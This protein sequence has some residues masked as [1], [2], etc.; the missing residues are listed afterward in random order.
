MMLSLSNINLRFIK[1]SRSRI[2]MASQKSER[3][4]SS[5]VAYIWFFKSSGWIFS[6]WDSCAEVVFPWR[7]PSWSAFKCWKGFSIFTQMD[8]CTEISNPAIFLWEKQAS[9]NIS[10]TWSTS[11]LVKHLAATECMWTR[12]TY[13]ISVA[14][15]GFAG[16]G[17]T[18]RKICAVEMRSSVGS[19]A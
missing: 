8:F 1:P 17:P 19:I 10:Y 4:F 18:L 16:S 15:W 12:N 6:N 3:V 7:P 2:F 13:K 11:S 9:S 5:K 14:V